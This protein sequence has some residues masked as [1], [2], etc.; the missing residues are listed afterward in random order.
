MFSLRRKPPE[1]K[2]AKLNIVNALQ[3]QK[4]SNYLLL[5]DTRHI[6]EDELKTMIAQIRKAGIQNVVGFLLQGGKRTSVH[7]IDRSKP[8]RR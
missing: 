8:K 3:L 1:P 5:A 2:A 7:F 6:T 4:D